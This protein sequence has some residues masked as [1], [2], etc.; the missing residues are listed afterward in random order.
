MWWL[1]F[2]AQNII[3]VHVIGYHEGAEEDTRYLITVA[4]FICSQ[5][6][7][8]LQSAMDVL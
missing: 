8:I 7:A 4:C 1:H 5:Q 3:Y 6:P 2:H